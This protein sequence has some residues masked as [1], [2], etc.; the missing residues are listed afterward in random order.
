MRYVCC[1]SALL[2]GAALTGAAQEAAVEELTAQELAVVQ[3]I[4]AQ[5]QTAE[6]TAAA[7]APSSQAAPMQ[8]PPSVAEKAAESGDITLSEQTKQQ[9]WEAQ[10]QTEQEPNGTLGHET[11]DAPVVSDT[12]AQTAALSQAS[13]EG[14]EEVNAATAA[15]VFP[16]EQPETKAKEEKEL[17]ECLTVAFI[18]ID[19]AFNEH[20]RTQA[21]KQQIDVKIKAKEREVEN[22]KDIIAALEAENKLLSRQLAEL[23]P[24]YERIVTDQELLPRVPESADMLELGNVLNRLTFSGCE[25]ISTSPLNSPARLDDVTERIGANKKIIAER[26]FFIDNYKYQTREE[27]LTLEKEEV[28]NILQDI[29]TEIKSFAKKR[30]IGAVVR[31]D[32]ILYGQQPVNVTKDFV[33]TLKKSKKYRKKK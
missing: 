19:I 23:K 20:P 6:E 7:A 33:S 28:K 16:A 13:A 3:A 29:Y 26:N 12:P 2:F 8:A 9:A 21:V 15:P 22:A 11:K 14:T 25:I 24:F 31:K 32:E 10:K 30:N 27:I 17:K 4:K 18:D 1:L 5:N